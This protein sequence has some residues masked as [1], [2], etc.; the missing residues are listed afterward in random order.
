MKM[1]PRLAL[2]LS[3]KDIELWWKDEVTS[4]KGW[5]GVAGV[6]CSL[7]WSAVAVPRRQRNAYHVAEVLHEVA[8]LELWRWK[9]K[10]PNR[11]KNDLEVCHLALCIAHEY[12]F[13]NEVVEHLEK[14]MTRELVR[15]QPK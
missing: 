3:D 14:D 2:V 4:E 9:G 7:S 10:H 1:H 6:A 13:S 12:G 5:S 15:T 11:L 8:H